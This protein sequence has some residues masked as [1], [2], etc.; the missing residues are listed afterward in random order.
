VGPREALETSHVEATGRLYV[1]ATRVHVKVRYRS[2][3]VPAIVEERAGGFR[4]T[5]ETPVTAVARG[6]VAVLYDGDTVVGAGV[7]HA[8]G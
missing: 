2:E 8:V 7:I 1:P 4:L 3:P 6:Q 5:L